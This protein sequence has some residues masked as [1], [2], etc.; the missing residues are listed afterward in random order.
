MHQAPRLAI[1][2]SHSYPSLNA[3]GFSW[4]SDASDQVSNHAHTLRVK[5]FYFWLDIL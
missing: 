1:S 2:P 5:D 3:S 4:L